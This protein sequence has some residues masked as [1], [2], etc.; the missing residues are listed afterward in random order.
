[1][2]VKDVMSRK[3]RSIT[4]E[5][6]IAEVM[7]MMRFYHCDGLPVAVN[8]KLVGYIEHKDVIEAF[9][10]DTDSDSSDG[11][12]KFD[13]ERIRNGNGSIARETVQEIMNKSKKSIT[14]LTH[15]NEVISMMLEDN[16]CHLAVTEGDRLVGT[17][18]FDDI[19]KAILSLASTKVAA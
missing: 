17:V 12:D 8:N 7:S 18:G 10:P 5:T 4:P 19:N 15:I 13:I 16:V 1:M 3:V 11:S 2:L 14:P 9:F 6:T